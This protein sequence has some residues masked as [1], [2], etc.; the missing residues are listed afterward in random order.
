MGMGVVETWMHGRAHSVNDA[1]GLETA[2]YLAIRT[3]RKYPIA[4]DGDR[5]V[6]VYV[7]VLIH[8][9]HNAISDEKV[10]ILPARTLRRHLAAR[11]T[12]GLTAQRS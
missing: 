7:A 3:D 4:V 11:P 1:I 5:A 9:K 8:R 2:G 10:A 6:G 12:V